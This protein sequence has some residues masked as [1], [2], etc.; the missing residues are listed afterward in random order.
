RHR[1]SIGEYASNKEAME[2]A[3]E[4]KSTFPDAWVLQTNAQ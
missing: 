2:A 1:I 4:L 3:K